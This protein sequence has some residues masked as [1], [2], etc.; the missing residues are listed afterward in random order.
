MINISIGKIKYNPFLY[1]I[2]F[3][4]LVYIVFLNYKNKFNLFKNIYFK[5][6]YLI[7]LCFLFNYDKLLALLLV[8][9]FIL[10]ISYNNTVSHFMGQLGTGRIIPFPKKIPLIGPGMNNQF[11]KPGIPGISSNWR[12]ISSNT[13]LNKQYIDNTEYIKNK[14]HRGGQNSNMIDYS[15]ITPQM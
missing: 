10:N 3:I 4:L 13:G 5:T 15:Y 14:N 12:N 2:Y 7:I 1:F 11:S 9:I 8:F 6:I